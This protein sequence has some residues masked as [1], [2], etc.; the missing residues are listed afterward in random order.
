MKIIINKASG[1]AHQHNQS[2]ETNQK[3]ADG[4]FIA[5]FKR[6]VSKAYI[7]RY[8]MALALLSIF[9]FLPVLAEE[10]PTTDIDNLLQ[11][12]DVSH[13]IYKNDIYGSPK[14]NLFQGSDGSK[15]LCYQARYGGDGD[16]TENILKLFRLQG[17][18]SIKLIEQNIDS[19]KFI[20][21]QGSLK[22][23]RGK[24]I[25]TLCDVCDGWDAAQYEDVFF[26][27]IKIDLESFTI[28]TELTQQ[29]KEELLSKFEGQSQRNIDEQLSYG[30]KNYPEF[31]KHVKNQLLH[32]LNITNQWRPIKNPRAAF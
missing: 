25:L 13:A 18:N 1:K 27:P 14:V 17:A 26:V 3:P 20:E 7:M 11:Q 8:S 29:Q 21:E 6:Y 19:V 30:N 12:V 28:E 31:V 22:A 24:Y 10:V 23:I 32:M 9:L 2:E 15:L 16:H 5:H 4:F